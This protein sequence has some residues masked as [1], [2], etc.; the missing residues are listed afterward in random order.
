M[1]RQN[2]DKLGEL[3]QPGSISHNKVVFSHTQADS[4]VKH[5]YANE[6]LSKVTTAI[7][8]IALLQERDG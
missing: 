6:S 7:D 2:Y 1:Y 8:L 4:K 5:F 3:Q